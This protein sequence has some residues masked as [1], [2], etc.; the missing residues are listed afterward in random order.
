MNK[1][2]YLAIPILF[3]IL[4]LAAQGCAVSPG[5]NQVIAKNLAFTPQVLTINQGDTVTWANKDN[6]DH[7]PVA[8]NGAFT[9]NSINPGKSAKFTFKKK[10]T[11]SYACGIH[12]YMKGKIIVK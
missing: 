4:V 5:K 12:P 2:K 1:I 9:L 10:G 3:I 7:A 8:D 11:Y 6:T